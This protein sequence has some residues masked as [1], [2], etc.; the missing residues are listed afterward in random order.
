MSVVPLTRAELVEAPDDLDELIEFFHARRWSDGLPI[1]PP[2]R[3]RVERMLSGTQRKPDEVIASIAPGY[4]AA[5]VERIAINAV[6]A[7]CRADYLPVL[8]AA[9]QAVSA[10]EFNL[11]G[12]QATTNPVAVWL[13]INGPVAEQ[14]GVNAGANCLGQ[15]AVANAT[16]G[17]ALRLILQNIGGALPGDMDRATHGQPGKFSFCCAENEAQSPWAPL[18]LDR[19]FRREQSTVTVVGAA[20]THNMNTHAKDVDDLLRVIADTM[21]FPASNDYWIGG[22]PW[23]ILSP[24][25]AE[26]LHAG[27][28]SKAE[29]QRRLF[30]QSTLRAGRMAARELMRTQA[31]RESKIGPITEDTMLAAADGPEGIGI[32]VAGGPGTHSVYVASFGDARAVTR[33]VLV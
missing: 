24:E 3:E 8:I 19:G 22:E 20:G 31:V 17:R 23:I 2:T 7:G 12:I 11:Q 32:L 26:V 4:G 29:V 13:I 28:L 15:G 1:V 18:H 30:E 9:T 25:H 16:L 5:T 14:L 27:G 21:A 10:P 6:M 33:E